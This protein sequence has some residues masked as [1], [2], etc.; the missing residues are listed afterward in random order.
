MEEASIS[1]NTTTKEP[2][3]DYNWIVMTLSNADVAQ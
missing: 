2:I 3:G 1:I